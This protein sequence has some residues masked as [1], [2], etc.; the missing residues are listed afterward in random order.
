MGVPSVTGWSER[1]FLRRFTSKH[2]SPSCAAVLAV[3]C[4]SPLSCVLVCISFFC[5]VYGFPGGYASGKLVKLTGTI[6]PVR[7]VVIF[8][9]QIECPKEV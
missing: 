3:T 5:R 2:V 9:D 7:K 8:Q 6:V 1:S 4:C